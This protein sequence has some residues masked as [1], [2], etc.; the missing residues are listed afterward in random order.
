MST[1]AK[2]PLVKPGMPHSFRRLPAVVFFRGDEIAR[3]A[4]TGMQHY[5]RLTFEDLEKGRESESI[6]ITSSE[7]S[8]AEHETLLRAPNI[9][10]IALSDTRFKDPRLDGVVYGYLPQN[11]PPTLVDRT[12]DNALDHI[13]LLAT[14]REV[15]EKLAGATREINELNLI[16]ASLAA[17]HDTEKLLAMILAKSREITRSDAGWLYLVEQEP[18]TEAKPV[19]PAG[20]RHHSRAR[21][22]AAQDNEEHKAVLRWKLAQNDS[23]TVPFEEAVLEINEESIAGY[24]A[25]TGDSVDLDDAYHLPEGVPYKIAR[26]LDED[27]GYRTKSILAVPMRGSKG[28]IVGVLQ[29]MNAKRSAD[30]KLTSV[31][32]VAAQVVPYSLRQQELVTSLASLAAVALENSRHYQASRALL[33]RALEALQ[34]TVKDGKADPALNELLQEAKR[35]KR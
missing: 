10:V 21:Q 17:E 16:G 20:H 23:V 35:L 29:L 3:R 7:K 12:V 33:E 27:S 25:R 8:I 30:A 11:T 22:A 28:E 6:V 26:Q 24:V 15:N 31:A 2:T 14:R 32:A 19:R 4:L 18:A 5:L 9:R 13:H 1:A 34:R